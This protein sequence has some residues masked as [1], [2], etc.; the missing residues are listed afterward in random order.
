F[1]APPR[2]GVTM[3]IMSSQ[4]SQRELACG[5]AQDRLW[6]F[7]HG[8]TQTQAGDIEAHLARCSACAASVARMRSLLAG[9]RAPSLSS[10]ARSATDQPVPERIGNYRIIR[11]IGQG[12]MG[13]VYEAEQQEPSRRVALKVIRDTGLVD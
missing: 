1:W 6:A 5:Q 7:V 8:D 4:P 12:G 13:V 9:I 11:R 10:A 3:A 2:D